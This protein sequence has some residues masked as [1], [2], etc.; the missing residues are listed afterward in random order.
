IEGIYVFDVDGRI[1]FATDP[2]AIGAIADRGWLRAHADATGGTWRLTTSDR[3]A[4]GN[5]L[6]SNS[7]DNVGGVALTYALSGVE[8]RADVM[9][10]DMA[11]AAL[12]LLLGFSL[13]AAVGS[14]LILR[15]FRNTFQ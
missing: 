3:P 7:S 10:W 8:A 12:L 4:L 11:K 2:A 1:V 15:S 13:L 6:A 14:F 5:R 9:L